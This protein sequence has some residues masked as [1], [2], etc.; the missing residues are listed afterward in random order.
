MNQ[1]FS[2]PGASE[3]RVPTSTGRWIQAESGSHLRVGEGE[4]GGL[5]LAVP[6][7]PRVG[8][9][10]RSRDPAPRVHRHHPPDQVL[11]LARDLVPDLRPEGVGPGDDLAEEVGEVGVLVEGVLACGQTEAWAESVKPDPVSILACKPCM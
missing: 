1:M 8:Q 2:E 7:A 3:R 9:A 6:R 5:A 4:G 11:G 10:A